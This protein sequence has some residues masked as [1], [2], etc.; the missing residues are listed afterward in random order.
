MC[1]IHSSAVK[2]VPYDMG[3]LLCDSCLHGQQGLYDIT[4]TYQG[5]GERHGIVRHHQER[6]KRCTP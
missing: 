3:H 4:S 6:R 1:D 2:G 5:P